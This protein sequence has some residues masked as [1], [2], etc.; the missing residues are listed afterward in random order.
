M[1]HGNLDW[2]WI[3]LV[4]AMSKTTLLATPKITPAA[5]RTPATLR[6]ARWLQERIER[7]EFQA[8][9]WL[10]TERELARQFSADRSTIRAAI[11]HLAEQGLVVRE[12]GRRP[13]VRSG[14]LT[15]EHGD[16]SSAGALAR[17]PALQTIA[18]IIPQP[19]SY[20]ALS[21]IQRGI[22]RALR[23]QESPYRLIVFD[24]QGETWERSVALERLAL[25]ALEQDGVA[26]GII[27]SIGGEKTLPQIR[28]LIQNGVPL[29]FL[30]RH[31]KEVMG[32]FVG[33]DNR[34]AAY[35]A[36]RSLL[37]LGHRRIAHL[38]STE[39]ALTIREREL[40][41][42]DALL[43]QGIEP[44]PSLIYRVEEHDDLYPDIAPA[45]DH[46]LALPE[47]PTALFAMKDLLAHSFIRELSARG[48]Q[49]PGD[50]S[51]VGF[52][53]HDRHSL[54][55]PILTTVHQ[56][57]ENMG[58]RAAELLLQRLASRDSGPRPA[59]HVLLPAPLIVRSTSAALALPEVAKAA[60]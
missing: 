56:P 1:A 16:H 52:D 54:Q 20:P 12:A 5:E 6:V 46:F 43:S 4:S 21:L 15:G 2:F 35:E 44:L 26:G 29:T 8:G 58:L 41:Y 33:V 14:P 39:T 37:A 27:W 30:D 7:Q 25:E 22:L 55:T 50:I 59:Q 13:Q 11:S 10:P 18:A 28:R 17:Q 38:T 19:L 51:V 23:Q 45:V 36:V 3:C 49:V 40:G 57:F 31:P 60:R 48:L 24:N 9:E 42:R 34:T 53:D 32:D 47:P